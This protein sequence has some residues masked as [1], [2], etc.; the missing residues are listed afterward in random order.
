MCSEP[1]RILAIASVASTAF[2]LP[3]CSW[4]ERRTEEPYDPGQDVPIDAPEA[5]DAD[6][7]DAPS[8]AA[9]VLEG[10][11][12]AEEIEEVEDLEGVEDLDGESEDEGAEDTDDLNDVNGG[13]TGGARE[14]SGRGNG[15]IGPEILVLLEPSARAETLGRAI[16]DLE[17]E[18]VVGLGEQ[19]IDRTEIAE[20]ELTRLKDE[21][22]AL[23]PAELI[24]SRG[25]QVKLAIEEANATL[26]RLSEKLD[27]VAKELRTRGAP[28][29]AE[30]RGSLPEAGH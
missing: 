3:A 30:L 4:F 16:R 23:R 6:V 27:L 13:G 11:D 5:D 29:P 24:G 10:R 20:R 18:S 8:K 25:E 9:R 22:G 1:L 2:F 28:I 21:L 14:T 7:D 26:D 17:T 15:T 12:T 19:L